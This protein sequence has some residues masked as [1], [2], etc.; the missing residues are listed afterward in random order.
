MAAAVVPQQVGL[1]H[2]QSQT[3]IQDTLQILRF[4]IVLVYGVGGEEG[5]GGHLLGVTHDDRL[6]AAS[7]N[8]HSLAGGKLGGLVKYHDVEGLARGI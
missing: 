6:R 8:A 1:G 7:Q 2:V 5:G 3:V 4:Q